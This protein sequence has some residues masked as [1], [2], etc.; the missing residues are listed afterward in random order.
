MRVTEQLISMWARQHVSHSLSELASAQAAVSTGVR[1]HKPSDDPVVASELIK[2]DEMAA[3]I[4]VRQRTLEGAGRW[5]GAT[6]VALNDISGTMRCI[7]DLALRSANSA[8]ADTER[9]GVLG[10]MEQAMAHLL[11]VANQ[12][13][14]GRYIFAGHRT[15]TRPFEPPA[16]PGGVPTYLGDGGQIVRPMAHGG[17]LAMNVPGEVLF[18]VGG[19]DPTVPDVFVS[20]ST[21]HQHIVNG[22]ADAISTQSLAD[23]EAIE[24]HLLGIRATL[25]AS[26]QRVEWGKERLTDAKLRAD[27]DR[28]ELA[29]EDLAEALVT[30]QL[31]VT[32]Y[33]ATLAAAARLVGRPGL[34]SF[35]A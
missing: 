21:L 5:L 11:D 13:L 34:V 30:L 1:V 8:T 3:R 20:L 19:I 16:G 22:D 29:G 2:Q 31:R 6:D 18:N 15:L 17:L 25:G 23:L 4:G 33:E 9:A 27:I 35:L 28:A 14:D 26:V 10:E 12:R 24:D 7:R 32:A